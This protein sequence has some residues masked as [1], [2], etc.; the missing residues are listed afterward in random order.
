MRK[1]EK[2]S[3]CLHITAKIVSAAIFS[4]TLSGCT[5][6][7]V[8]EIVNMTSETIGV[9]F[10]ISDDLFTSPQNNQIIMNSGEKYSQGLSFSSFANRNYSI[11]DQDK[12]S[13]FLSMFKEIS[14]ILLESNIELSMNDLEKNKVGRRRELSIHYYFITIENGK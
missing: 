2:H 8:F 6:G 13:T 9:K 14:I 4:I 5:P 7:F 12:T 1:A 10:S 11:E 3:N